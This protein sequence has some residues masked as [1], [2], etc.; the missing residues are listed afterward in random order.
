MGDQSGRRSD[1]GGARCTCEGNR[2]HKARPAE[3][4]MNE[5]VMRV[6]SQYRRP[7][8][9]QRGLILFW[10]D[11]QLTPCDGHITILISVY[12][13]IENWPRINSTMEALRYSCFYRMGEPNNGSH[14]IYTAP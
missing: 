3:G 11:Q 4:N 5:R 8:D 7:L 2:E 6:C 1:G 10:F 9:P 14:H 13:R 12:V